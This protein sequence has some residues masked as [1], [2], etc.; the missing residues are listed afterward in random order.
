MKRTLIFSLLILSLESF[1]QTQNL[2][3][4]TIVI[5][6][7]PLC[8]ID[9]NYPAIQLGAEVKL[10]N[11]LSYQ[12]EAG[13]IFRQTYVNDRWVN[14]GGFKIRSEIKSYKIITKNSDVLNG[15]YLAI[16][17]F[18]TYTYFYREADFRL[19]DGSTQKDEHKII[20]HIIGINAKIGYQKIFKSGILLEFYVGIGI[21][22]RKT[23]YTENE[24][25][26]KKAIF[27]ADYIF[28]GSE[29]EG[30]SIVPNLPMSIKIGYAF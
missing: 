10:A 4:K 3:E 21:K 30:E 20:K 18:Y 29:R 16:E 19:D 14:G 28:A 9:P 22:Y 24:Y 6:F 11:S 15:T 2:K 17:P 23:T 25:E 26:G 5:K 13:Y 7:S 12:Q 8:L 1:G 27:P